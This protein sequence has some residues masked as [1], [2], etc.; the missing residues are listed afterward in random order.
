[1]WL[2]PFLTSYFMHVPGYP[3]AIQA[4]TNIFSHLQYEHLLSNMMFLGVFG[5]A[6]H[7]LVGR[8]TFLGTYMAAGAVGSLGTLYWANTLGS[9][10]VHV[11]GASAAIWGI[12][13]L[14]L[15]LTEQETIKIPFTQSGTVA[16]WPKGLFAGFVAMEIRAAIRSRTKVSMNDH[17]SHFGGLLTGVTVAGYMRA[18]GFHERRKAAGQEPKVV[19]VGAMLKEEVTEIKDGIKKVVKKE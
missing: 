11:L 3:R 4:V 12:T 16:F 15:L 8:G 10:S 19:D 7:E 5:Y 14:Y 17:A 18:T 9:P 1:M 6:C 2:W 13:A